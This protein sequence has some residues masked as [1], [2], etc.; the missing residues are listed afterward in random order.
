[1]KKINFHIFYI[2]WYPL[3]LNPSTGG[4]GWGRNKM[5][6]KLEEIVE[7]PHGLSA[8]DTR[9]INTAVEL[10]KMVHLSLVWGYFLLA[11]FCFYPH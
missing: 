10:N 8:C 6:Y 9:G 4:G 7:R 2:L 5:T 1:M 11:E 3:S